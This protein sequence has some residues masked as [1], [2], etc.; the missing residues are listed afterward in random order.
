MAAF[1]ALDAPAATILI[2]DLFV[3]Y[4]PGPVALFLSGDALS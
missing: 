2:D 1:E 4:A 3:G